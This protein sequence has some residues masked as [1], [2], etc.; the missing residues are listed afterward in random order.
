MIVEARLPLLCVFQNEKTGFG[1][2]ACLV[3]RHPKTSLCNPKLN[4]E[5]EQ[6][7]R[8]MNTMTLK[9]K[10]GTLR[11]T[12]NFGIHPCNTSQHLPIQAKALKERLEINR[13]IR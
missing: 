6:R 8:E 1:Q 11:S 10:D 13:T 4:E 2:C 12:T 5:T 7:N 9:H 3:S